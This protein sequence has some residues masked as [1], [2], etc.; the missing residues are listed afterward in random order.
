MRMTH[1]RLL[2][3]EEI[4]QRLGANVE[5]VRRWLRQGRL[6]GVRPGGT[7]LGWRVSE[8]ELA[9]FLSGEDTAPSPP[10]TPGEETTP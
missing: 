1:E 4:A 7:K 9:R 10:A 6:R 3:V 5:T 8:R 2:T